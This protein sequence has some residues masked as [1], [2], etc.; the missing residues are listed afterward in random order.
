MRRRMTSWASSGKFPSN[1]LDGKIDKKC[2]L[3]QE[4][5]TVMASLTSTLREKLQGIHKGGAPSS[6]LRHEKR[7]KLFVRDRIDTLLDAHSP[8]LELGALAGDGIYED[9]P[10]AGIVTGIGLVQGEEVM[11]IGNDATVK[12]GTTRQW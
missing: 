9:V 8:F 12:G 10:A 4:G 7:G 3:F 1:I 6:R 2:P 11:I 5:L